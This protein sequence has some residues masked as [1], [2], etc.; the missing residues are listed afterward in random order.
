M[1]D[2]YEKIRNILEANF[3]PSYEIYPISIKVLKY[4]QKYEPYYKNDLFF[5]SLKT[6]NKMAIESRVLKIKSKLVEVR[7]FNS[8]QDFLQ[9]FGPL[10]KLNSIESRERNNTFNLVVNKLIDYDTELCIIVEEKLNSIDDK[11]CN[12]I[13]KNV[14]NI[15][16]NNSKGI[17]FEILLSLF[18][19]FFRLIFLLYLKNDQVDTTLTL[20]NFGISKEDRILGFNFINSKPIDNPKNTNKIDNFIAK[21]YMFESFK[22]FRESILINLHNCNGLSYIVDYLKNFYSEIDYIFTDKYD[23]DKIVRGKIEYVEVKYFKFLN[24]DEIINVIRK[25]LI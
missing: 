4:F 22:I 2:N 23:T 25:K 3:I 9:Y 8:Q 12:M 18:K 19:T 17:N 16:R 15:S 14:N 10:K 5:S 13:V 24:I 21:R 7:I 20:K 11:F 6:S 1:K